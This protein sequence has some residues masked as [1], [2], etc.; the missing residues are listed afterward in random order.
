MQP[1]LHSFPNLREASQALA[2]QSAAWLTHTLS[3]HSHA[4]IAVPGGTT[5]GH[6]LQTLAACPLAWENIAFLLTDERW[7]ATNNPRSNFRL[8]LTCLGATAN[9]AQSLPFYQP[10]LSVEDAQ[11]PVGNAVKHLFSDAQ[12]SVCVLGMGE[13]GHF[14]SL[15]P[16]NP[17]LTEGLTTN[18]RVLAVT[19]SGEDRLSLSLH[20]ICQF[21]QVALL[22]AGES[23]RQLLAS[24]LAGKHQD[25][26]IAHLFAQCPVEVYQ[27]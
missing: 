1:N 21:S 14:A 6:F 22:I 26:P 19:Q 23:K 25:L 11:K 8:L 18:H 16:N 3:Q 20:A 17:R 5:P 10:D 27:G 2:E 4:C 7:V 15:F 24:I 13:D 12:P 9:R